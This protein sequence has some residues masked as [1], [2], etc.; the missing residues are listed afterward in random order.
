[1][2]R[3]AF[4]Q[5]REAQRLRQLKNVELLENADFK[6]RNWVDSTIKDAEEATRDMAALIEPARVDQETRGEGGSHLGKR[7]LWALR[8]NTQRVEKKRSYLLLCLG[9]LAPVISYLHQLTYSEYP[10]D[11]DDDQA[12]PSLPTNF[13]E[14]SQVNIGRHRA[15]SK[16]FSSSISLVLPSEV[17]SLVSAEEMP[18]KGTQES[19]AINQEVSEMLSWRRSKQSDATKPQSQFVA[20]LE[21]IAPSER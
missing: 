2:T 1:M 17:E 6:V 7:M 11:A 13:D 5:V 16:N 21:S 12:R 3:H 4:T 18:R 20:E 19:V 8:N 9:S 15:G 10:V 14:I